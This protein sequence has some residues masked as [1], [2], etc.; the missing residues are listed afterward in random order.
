MK[1]KTTEYE[2]RSKEVDQLLIEATATSVDLEKEVSRRKNVIEGDSYTL[3]SRRTSSSQKVG[4]GN[5]Y[6]AGIQRAQVDSSRQ[7]LEEELLERYHLSIEEVRRLGLALDK[8][9]EILEKA[10]RA[11]RAELGRCRRY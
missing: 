8:T 2:Q 10:I 9:L 6:Q 7:A 11:L 3:N 5:S 4:K 1:V